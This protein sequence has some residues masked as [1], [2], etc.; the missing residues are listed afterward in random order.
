[1]GTV[2]MEELLTRIDNIE[3]RDKQEFVTLLEI[4]SHVTFFGGI[5]K[6][7]CE[8]AKNGQCSLF[9][10]QTNARNKIPMATECRIPGCDANH[11]HCHLEISNIT[12]T[13]CPQW[14]SLQVNHST[15]QNLPRRKKRCQEE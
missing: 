5:K 7:N 9:Y 14:S 2:E 11:G 15:N 8:Y 10:L 13:F 1:M 4:M 3:K 12:C 6:T